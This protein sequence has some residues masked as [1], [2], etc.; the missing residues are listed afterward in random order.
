MLAMPVM[1]M[2]ASVQMNNAVYNVVVIKGFPMPDSVETRM[3]S[4]SLDTSILLHPEVI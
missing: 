3:Q 4:L 2:F 1:K